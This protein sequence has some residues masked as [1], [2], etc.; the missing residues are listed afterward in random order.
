[1]DEMVNVI[2]GLSKEI[3]K[4]IK[5]LSKCK[6]LD[7]KK[8]LAEIINL[9]CESMGVFFNAMEMADLGMYEDFDTD[10]SNDIVDFKSLKKSKKKKDK[11]KDDIPF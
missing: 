4:N 6:D 11:D 8:K 3:V 5:D 2:D 7:Q 9:L 1:M 10:Y